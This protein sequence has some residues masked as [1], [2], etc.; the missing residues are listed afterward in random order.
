MKEIDSPHAPKAIG[1]YSQAIHAGN[2][3][4]CSGQIPITPETNDVTLFSGDVGKQTELVLKNLTAVLNAAG[5]TLQHVV[6]TTLYL[7][8]MADFA[9]V[10]AVYA[11]AFGD[12]HPARACV[13]V[14]RLPKD[15]QIEIDAIA[16]LEGK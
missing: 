4:Y 1:P 15:V 11:Q 14:A 8:N 9:A 16:Y 5:C 13:Q 10:N 2:W 7:T 6:K 3:V 12:H